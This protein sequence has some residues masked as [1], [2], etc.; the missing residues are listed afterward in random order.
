MV[1]LLISAI[2]TAALPWQALATTGWDRHQVD[3]LGTYRIQGKNGANF[4]FRLDER[5][6]CV[7]PA[8][9]GTLDANGA[10]MG[11]GCPPDY[12]ITNS[13][14]VIRYPNLDATSDKPNHFLVQIADGT[15]VGPLTATV[16]EQTSPLAKAKLKWKTPAT[17]ADTFQRFAWSA[18]SLTIVLVAGLSLGLYWIWKTSRRSVNSK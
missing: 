10:W 18:L 14:I 3:I 5:G 1:R 2:L 7:E 16:F 13:H 9:C 4:V 11:L 15:V 6:Q 8:L 12:A 17:A